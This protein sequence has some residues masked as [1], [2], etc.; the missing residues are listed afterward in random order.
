MSDL[1]KKHF[2]QIVCSAKLRVDIKFL[3]IFPNFHKK[4]DGRF[5]FKFSLDYSDGALRN[6]QNWEVIFHVSKF[7]HGPA[8]TTNFYKPHQKNIGLFPSSFPIDRAFRDI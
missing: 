4:T 6:L 7:P 3:K 8:C 2:L 5:R 1:K